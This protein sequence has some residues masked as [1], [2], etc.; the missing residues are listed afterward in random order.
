MEI[1]KKLIKWLILGLVAVTGLGYVVNALVIHFDELKETRDI[2]VL[3]DPALFVDKQTYI[4]GVAAIGMIIVMYFLFGNDDAKRA[5]R[6]MSSK[7]KAVEGAL[8][9][10]RF[11]T[12]KERDFNFM[13]YDYSQLHKSKKDGVP[14]RAFM[15]GHSLKVN[16]SNP[17]HALIIGATGSGKTTTFINPMVQILG[18]TKA[19][20]SMILTD[21]KGELFQMHSQKLKEKGYKVMVLDLRDPYSSYRWNPLE[22]IFKMYAEYLE[23]G[24]GIFRRNDSVN[25]SGLTLHNDKES[26]GED[27]YEYKGKAYSNP[28]ELK[29]LI[30]VAR[31]HVFD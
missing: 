5:K 10:S 29:D 22:T 31:Q 7:A 3:W 4:Y 30:K 13:P 28:K 20:S 8:E 25:E 1:L 18:E 24:T 21:P 17:M 9:N 2:N 26:Y 27:W 14:V 15:Q 23:G 11:M 16:I 6:M 19:G 12:D